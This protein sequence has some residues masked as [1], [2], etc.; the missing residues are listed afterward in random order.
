MSRPEPVHEPH[1]IK[2]VR[3][4]FFPS[5]TERKRNLIQADFNLLNL[6]PQQVTFDMSS[7]GS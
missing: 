6:L 1:K 7:W 4:T 2:T 5:L 3:P